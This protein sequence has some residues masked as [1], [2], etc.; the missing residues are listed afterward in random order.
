MML[1]NQYLNQKKIYNNKKIKGTTSKEE[2]NY[3]YNFEIENESKNINSIYNMFFE[4]GLNSVAEEIEES[5]IVPVIT[6]P[7][8][9]KGFRSVWDNSFKGFASGNSESYQ[10]TFINS[11]SKRIKTNPLQDTYYVD[12]ID[13]NKYIQKS[14]S[15]EKENDKNSSRTQ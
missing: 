9:A 13:R 12:D 1:K 7:E 14:K 5:E 6:T 8:I 2:E 4:L 11:Q 3:S 10:D 15:S